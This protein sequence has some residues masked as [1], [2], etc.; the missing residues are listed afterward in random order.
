MNRSF[1]TFLAS[2]Q[3][4]SGADETQT[5]ERALLRAALILIGAFWTIH[6]FMMTVRFGVKAGD[7]AAP[8]M[9]SR[10]G[11]S[12]FGGLVCFGLFLALKRFRTRRFSMQAALACLSSSWAALIVALVNIHALDDGN[13]PGDFPNYAALLIYA[14]MYWYWFYLSWSAAFLA[15]SFS[16]TAADQERRALVSKTEAHEAHMRALRYQINPHFLFNALNSI[17]SLI[18]EDREEAE[19]AIVRLSEFL[20]SSL[21]LD[22]LEEI[23]LAEEFALQEAYLAIEM[24]RFPNR[25]RVETHLPAELADFRVPCLILQP[26]VE[27]AVKHGVRRSNGLTTLKISACRAQDGVVVE[28]EDDADAAQSAAMVESGLGIGLNNV[29]KRLAARYRD[30]FRFECSPGPAGYRVEMLFPA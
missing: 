14:F 17:A 24:V 8:Y 13:F 4:G 26:I 12:L 19:R 29:R 28:I 22:P 10:L 15:V 30:A 25:L 16:L 23:S 1:F 9:V 3:P 27:N 5:T 6:F 21:A 20:R 7:L 11:L 18:E 2:P